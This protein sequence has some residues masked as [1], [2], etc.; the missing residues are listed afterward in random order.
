MNKSKFSQKN[1]AEIAKSQ[2]FDT[3]LELNDELFDVATGAGQC[4]VTC[5]YSCKLTCEIT[6][7]SGQP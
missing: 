1:S 2:E 5:G 6:G 3:P 4:G 7:R